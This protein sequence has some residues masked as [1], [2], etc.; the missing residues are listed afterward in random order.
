M[1]R[2]IKLFITIPFLV[3]VAFLVGLGKCLGLSY[4]QISVYFNLYFQGFLLLLSGMLPFVASFIRLCHD[5][6]FANGIMTL[7]FLGYGSI[8]LAGFIWMI[9]HYK[10]TAEY[11]F[12]K[13]VADLL[14]VADNWHLSI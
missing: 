3:C 11:A 4:K 8:Y 10:G 13:C 9:I 7:A 14:V 2:I 1:H 5:M 12:D 6:T